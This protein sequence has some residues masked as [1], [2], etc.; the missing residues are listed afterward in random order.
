[1]EEKK[2]NSQTVKKATGIA[3]TVGIIAILLDYI[4]AKTKYYKHA[5]KAMDKTT[6]YMDKTMKLVEDTLD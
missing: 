1:M 6:D 4:T 5:A 3:A 2:F